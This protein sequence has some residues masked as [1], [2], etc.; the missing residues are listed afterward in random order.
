[1]NDN[2]SKINLKVGLIGK[3]LTCRSILR[4]EGIPF[5]IID[6]I[7]SNN[8]PAP[9]IVLSDKIN[10]SDTGAI[11]EYVRG[12][13]IVI[14]DALNRQLIKTI[15]QPDNTR[16]VYIDIDLNK[17]LADYSSTAK[18]FITSAGS[19]RERVA[20]FPKAAA[21][22]AL[23]G[24]VKSACDMRGIPFVRLWY[25][26]GRYNSLFNFRFDLDE[27]IGNELENIAAVARNYKDCTT[28]FA[29]CASFKKNSYKIKGLIDEGFDVQSHG[30]YHHTY[31]DKGQ[32]R[33]NIQKSLGYFKM[34]N[35]RVDGFAAPKGR[36]N[37]GL[38]ETLQELG[39]SYSSEFALDYDN[40]PFYPVMG[41][42]FSKVLQI[43]IY[44]VC[45]GL[46]N[47][48]AINDSEAIKKYMLSVITN[49]FIRNMPIIIYGHPGEQISKEPVLLKEIYERID[50]LNGVWKVNLSGLAGWWKKRE[51]IDF[52]ELSFDLSKKALKY[53]LED[54]LDFSGAYLSIQTLRDK[55]AY[56]G[57]FK[58][59]D[60][61]LADSLEYEVSESLASGPQ[62][63]LEKPWPSPCL[64]RIKEYMV[65]I[66]DWEECTPADELERATV[67]SKIKYFLRRCGFDRIKINV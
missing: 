61:F 44:P 55:R 59:S 57:I 49:K 52:S 36:W 18:E 4:Q 30:Y 2:N 56:R 51:R 11:M 7:K 66:L 8:N 50:T 54:N 27:D 10:N 42:T 41:R 13:G 64:K 5:F 29:C 33:K 65:D 14:F 62:A 45:W 15:G 19:V 3:S 39:F 60:E 35:H 9:V 48:A 28:M 37:P 31:S 67:P 25:Y 53:A 40:L 1:M 22:A 26:P 17:E 47:D 20:L 21:R 32:N 58:E 16:L 23:S 43:P 12:G 63:C 24:A 34:L 6:D 46:Y 38:Q